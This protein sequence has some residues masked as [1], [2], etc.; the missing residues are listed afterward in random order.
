M[1]DPTA[2]KEFRIRLSAVKPATKEIE[3]SLDQKSGEFH[4]QASLIS[5]LSDGMQAFVGLVSSIYS[6]EHEII[7]I[8]EPE[9][10]LHPLLASRLGAELAK[11]ASDR[12]ATLIVSTRSSPFVLGCIEGSNSIDIIRLTYEQQTATV[13]NIPRSEVKSLFKSALLRSSG[14]VQGLLHRAVIVCESNGDRVIY[15]EINRRLIENDRGIAD[16]HF[17]NV[18]NKQTAHR[19]VAPMRKLG[20]PAVAIVDLDFLKCKGSDWDQLIAACGIT[21][22]NELNNMVSERD[23]ILF[24]FEDLPRPSD[25]SEPI[26]RG[27]IT[28]LTQQNKSRLD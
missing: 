11:I 27:G 16:A 22:Q 5:D 8:D 26:K 4:G 24:A 15:D 25:D 10:F 21:D 9:F 12:D 2:M 17:V 18:Q 19:I 14:V 7:L 28:H 1:I 13:R 23:H 3:Q 6:L 20:I